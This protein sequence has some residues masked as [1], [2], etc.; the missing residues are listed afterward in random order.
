VGY[1][2]EWAAYYPDRPEESTLTVVDALHGYWIQVPITATTSPTATVSDESAGTWQ[3]AGELLPED[4]PLSLAAGWNLVGYLPRQPLTI[5]T[6]LEGMA[7][8]YGAV[9]GFHRTGLSYYPDLDESFNTLSY[10]APG[11]GYWISAAQALAFAYPTTDITGTLPLTATRAARARAGGVRHAE[12][13]A[14]VQPTY[15]W[16]SFFGELTLADESPLPAGTIIL[17]VDPQGVVCG[18]TIV[19][20]PGQ[21]GLLACYGDDPG[22]GADEG[23][24]PGDVIQ[25][26]VS[27]EG[28]QPDGQFIGAGLWTGH[29]N[30]WEVEEGAL[31]LTD[32]AITKQVMP[33]AALPGSTITYTLAYTNVGNIVAK[34]VVISDLLP[35]ELEVTGYGSWGAAITPVTGSE[36]LA[37]LVEDLGPGEGGIITVTALLSPALT[38]GPVLTNTAIITASL[39]AWPEDNVAQAVLR[40]IPP[41]A[42]QWRIWLPLVVR[43]EF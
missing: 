31:L 12:W 10:M 42:P 17:A 19:W 36:N 40:V 7:G 9:L 28:T 33:E 5:T 38:S 11:Y 3:M 15:Q 8:G 23:A 25:M 20:E 34:G 18:A 39:E 13:L 41:P 21:Y 4:Q 27:S 6:A 43:W 37:W 26:F 29:G 30:R 16:A 22:T 2:G 35:L 14:G 1:D 24:R 32:L